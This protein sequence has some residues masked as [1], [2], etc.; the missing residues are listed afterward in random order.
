MEV[1]RKENNK[2]EERI[3][4]YKNSLVN[5]GISKDDLKKKVEDLKEGETL[6]VDFNEEK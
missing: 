5:E 1:I 2:Y 3:N 6:K 4:Y